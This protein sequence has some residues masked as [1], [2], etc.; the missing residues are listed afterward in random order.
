MDAISELE[1]N[2]LWLIIDP[3]EKSPYDHDDVIGIDLARHNEVILYKIVDYLPKLKH[4]M[5][6]CPFY[7]NNKKVNVHH[8]VKHLTNLNDNLS[9][10]CSY[11][12]KNNITSVVYMGFHHGR[13]ILTRSLSPIFLSQKI[14]NLALYIKRDC[15]CTLPGDDELEADRKSLQYVKFI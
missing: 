9:L 2:A 1:H 4:V 13:C 3:W 6:S 11:L 10:L 7:E 5:V 14:N 8:S 12:Q 15:V